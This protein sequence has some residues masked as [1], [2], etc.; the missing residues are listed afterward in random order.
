MQSFIVLGIIP[1]THIQIN[2]TDWLVCAGVFVL[3]AS[4]L[5]GR[6]TISGWLLGLYIFRSVRHRRLSQLAI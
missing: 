6:R 2:F 4:I 1:G 5:F 3:F